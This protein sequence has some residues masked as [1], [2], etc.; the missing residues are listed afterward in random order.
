VNWLEDQ[1]NEQEKR[2]Q[3]NQVYIPEPSDTDMDAVL[4]GEKTEPDDKMNL[5]DLEKMS[6]EEVKAWKKTQLK[7]LMEGTENVMKELPM[8][9]E[10][11]FKPSKSELKEQQ[12]SGSKFDV[13]FDDT[14][15]KKR[16]PQK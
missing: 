7:R 6:N 9:S 10:P 2:Y 3:A 14:A 8:S 15:N 1:V 16:R 12:R 11:K 4:L 5:K 13:F